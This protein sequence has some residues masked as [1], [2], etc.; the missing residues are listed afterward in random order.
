MIMSRTTMLSITFACFAAVSTLGCKAYRLKPPSGFAEV[1]ARPSSTRLKA[2]DDVGLNVKVFGNVR[3]GTLAFWSEDLARKLAE[4]GYTLTH[5]QAIAS[6]NG[7]PGT[8]FDFSYAT[9]DGAPKF[10]SVLLFVTDKHKIVVEIAGKAELAER[11]LGRLDEIAGATKVRGCRSWTSLCE[12]PQPPSLVAAS[13][14]AA[15][16]KPAPEAT[17]TPDEGPEAEPAPMDGPT[18]AQAQAASSG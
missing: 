14:E 3:G 10:Y 16:R 13:A 2:S 6:D 8:R 5:Q 7:K 12:G 15:A 4:R 17:P 18:S 1:Y 11:Y 9:R